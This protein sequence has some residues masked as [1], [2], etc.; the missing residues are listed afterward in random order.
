MD[1]YG[2]L[3]LYYL[4]G[5]SGKSVLRLF[6]NIEAGGTEQLLP[7][8]TSVPTTTP[9]LADIQYP[10]GLRTDQYFT[11]RE[12]PTTVSNKARIK[13][14]KGNTLVWN[15]LVQN[16]NFADTSNWYARQSTFTVSDNIATV[17][18][19]TEGAERGMYCLA[20][21]VKANHKYLLSCEIKPPIQSTA[22]VSFG[23]GINYGF[24][25]VIQAGQWNKCQGIV[26][27]DTDRNIGY[28]SLIRDSLTPS[29][30][31]QFKNMM[32]IDLTQM[33]LDISS[34]SEFTS[35][36]SLP[37][38]D[39]NQGTL[40]S[41]MGNGIKTTGKNLFKLN[42]SAT[43]SNII[44][45]IN[46]T[47][48]AVDVA[49]TTSIRWSTP[50]IGY[51]D[52]IAGKTYTASL[53]GGVTLIYGRIGGSTT[54]GQPTS[55]NQPNTSIGGAITSLITNITPSRTFV[56]NE[57]QRIYWYYCTDSGNAN[58]Q[59]FTFYP[60]IELNPIATD[61]E[62]YTS[63]TLSLPISTYFSNGMKSA[64]NV[65]D[66]LTETKAITRTTKRVFDGTENWEYEPNDPNAWWYLTIT[67]S[68]RETYTNVISNQF[69]VGYGIDNVIWI[70][71][72]QF[73][74]R[75][76]TNITP[77]GQT[78]EGLQEFK[79]YLASHPLTVIY[80]LATPTETPITTEDANEA[81]SLLMGKS[82]SS[83]NANQ[84][85]NIITKGE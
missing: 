41:F 5:L 79:T 27:N 59:E 58:H 3:F 4:K 19:S 16:G 62:S 55:S 28:Y 84:L 6:F 32:V 61:F 31:I 38:Y 43:S 47:T 42:P 50:Y 54:T 30:T 12:T 14:I 37:Y 85:I 71:F 23:G 74:V 51:T 75:T 10:D 49:D 8:N 2:L 81:L 26:L 78:A 83:N 11:Y 70:R 63:S 34:P 39:F 36:F 73:H 44:N 57:T 18:P 9:I 13:T 29:Q 22:R 69:P 72:G 25:T 33:G 48:G 45:A 82:V 46:E 17:T 65:Y 68:V 15:Q 52:V 1:Y 40:L 66:E 35:I 7:E 60:Q 64:G 24:D 80:E 20:F 53:K 67:D 76:G 56:A 21:P 77:S